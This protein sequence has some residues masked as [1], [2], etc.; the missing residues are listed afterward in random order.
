[1]LVD[2]EKLIKSLIVLA[3]VIHVDETSASINGARWWLHV[4]GTDKRPPI[5]CTSLAAGP[6]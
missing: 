4:A 1:M 2:V 5:T 3:H 6:R